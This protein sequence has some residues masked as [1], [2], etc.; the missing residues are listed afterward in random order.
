M[1]Y[2]TVS[3]LAILIKIY[4]MYVV[5]LLSYKFLTKYIIL[6]PRTSLKKLKWICNLE[7]KISSLVENR[8]GKILISSHNR[9]NLKLLDFWVSRYQGSNYVKRRWESWI[10]LLLRSGMR[11]NCLHLS[12]TSTNAVQILVC[13]SLHVNDFKCVLW[14]HWFIFLPGITFMIILIA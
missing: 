13:T 14:L 11:I 2:E 10:P 5:I 12:V 8:N 3:F 7:E 4:A 1:S 9:I 6:I